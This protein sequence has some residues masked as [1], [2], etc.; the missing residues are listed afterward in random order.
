MFL[1]HD[2]SDRLNDEDLVQR[3]RGGYGSSLGVLW[4]RYAH[5]LFGVAM[6]YLKNIEASKDA[7]MELFAELPTLLMKHE[8]KSFRPWLHTVM[9]N[10]CLMILRKTDPH[11]SIDPA[12]VEQEA[13]SDEAALHEA[14]LQALDAALVKLPEGQE[15]CIR[16]FYLERKSYQQV[17]E[18]TGIPVEQVRSHLQNGRRN[19]RNLL[20]HH[21]E[22]N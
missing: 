1:R 14:S 11:A 16:L 12:R 15:R 21:G 13:P 9:R 7:V 3:L 5:L 22:R 6:K 8:V 10:R 2:A 17:A 20:D 19:L 18:R 4:D